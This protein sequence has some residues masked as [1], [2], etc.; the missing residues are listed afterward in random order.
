MLPQ[1]HEGQPPWARPHDPG[2]KFPGILPILLL[3]VVARPR[4]ADRQRIPGHA[5]QGCAGQRLDP[6]PLATGS[7]QRMKK[8]PENNHIDQ[9]A[10]VRA[11]QSVDAQLY[12]QL[13][14]KARGD[15]A[16]LAKLLAQV[17]ESWL[18]EDC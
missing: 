12:Q 16:L 18:A 4:G 7:E 2:H 1:G 3:V 13:K 14:A 11:V 8:M 6:V 10:L 9:A 17:I 15:D 5:G